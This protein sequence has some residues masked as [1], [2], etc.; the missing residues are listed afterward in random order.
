LAAPDDPAGDG[1]LSIE[2][3]LLLPDG[4][5]R[6]VTTNART[7]SEGDPGVR[8]VARRIGT[9]LDIT[10]R[11]QAEERL[12]ASEE[13]YALFERG[14]NDGIWDW[15][16]QTGEHYHSPRWKEIVGSRDDAVPNTESSFFDRVHPDDA[17]AVTDALRRHYEEG[18]R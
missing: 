11:K 1:A 17:A 8:R 16:I 6:W 18:A 13:R 9:I 15:D 12:R 10:G 5:T 4:R 2:H 3:R 14:V 7:F